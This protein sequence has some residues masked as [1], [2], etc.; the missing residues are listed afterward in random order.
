MGRAWIIGM[1]IGVLA[2]WA[3][4]DDAIAL[5]GGGIELRV[6]ADGKIV[7]VRGADEGH[8]LLSDKLPPFFFQLTLNGKAR[9]PTAVRLDED[10]KQLEFAYSDT[11]ITAQVA[12]HSC[13]THLRL[14][15]R[16]VHGA[17]AERVQLLRLPLAIQGRVGRVV[18]V[19]RDGE[20][21][22]GVQGLNTHTRAGASKTGW[23]GYLYSC[24]EANRGGVIGA[25]MALF[26]CPAAEALKRIG[27]IE[28]A[29]GLPHPMLDGEWNKISRTA[30]RPY[31]IIR[32]SVQNMADVLSLAERGGFRY[33]YHSNPFDTW[34]H[35]VL[36]K[37]LFPEGDQ[38]LRQCADMAAGKGIRLGF[39]TLSGFI[40]TNDAYVT[41]VPD[42]RLGRLGS[43]TLAAD[44]DA[45]VTEI[46]VADA[47]PFKQRQ[48]LGAVLMGT[49]IATY[50]RLAEG[51]APKL[52]GVT[53]GAFGTTASAHRKGDD[54]GKL[55]D[56]NYRTLFPGI[57]NGMMDEMT[58]R[59][60][61]LVN[62]TG[63]GMMSFDGLEC[64]ASYEAGGDYPRNRF[65]DRCHRRWRYDVISGASNLLHYNWHWHTR[66]NW[67]ELTQS[68]KMDIDFYRAKNCEFYRDNL[69]PAGMGWWRISPMRADCEATRLEDVEYLLSKAAGNNATHA[70]STDPGILN[71]HGL[72]G[73]M[74]E[75]V[76]LWDD[77]R[78]GGAL[79]EAQR[80][81]LREKGKDFR[82]RAV[83][84][85]GCELVPVAYGPFYWYCSGAGRK[86]DSGTLTFASTGTPRPQPPFPIS[87][88]YAVQPI[89]FGVR[90]LPAYDYGNS[91]NIDLTPDPETLVREAGLHKEAPTIEVKRDGAVGGEAAL[92]LTASYGAAKKPSY[93]T[94]LCSTLPKA[95]NLSSH[96]GLGVWVEGDGKGE[97]LFIEIQDGKMVRP[98]YVPID[99]TGERYIELPL[100]EV[101]LKRF[102]DY[103][104]NNWSGFSSW[105]VT[106]K[107]FRYQRVAMVTMGYNAIP[108][109]TTVSCRVAGIKALRELPAKVSVLRVRCGEQE[110]T[111][112]PDLEPFQYLIYEGEGAA[113]VYDP[114]FREL[115]TVQPVGQ[116]TL[117]PGENRVG[118]GIECPG[119]A[120]WIRLQSRAVGAPERLAPTQGG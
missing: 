19:I 79:T 112:R 51:D 97:T 55:A 11:G 61:E 69:L 9:N 104:W 75:L 113:R 6:A 85:G 66:M 115:R 43:S 25:S 53:R 91:G 10:A 30:Q 88:P 14:T 48:A 35:F 67:G 57:A 111:F 119:P 98:Y 95:L 103:E 73:R 109:S 78:F 77:A 62:A 100:G 74:I 81:R 15:L 13:E 45:A 106:L 72:A 82:L 22:V 41:P 64:L 42:P 1:G 32:Y 40:T 86:S 94:R 83:P 107:G 80:E 108:P 58:D 101:S 120:P 46:P 44:I 37:K 8:E 71:R 7:G 60:V 92:R 16:A 5:R 117:Q 26:A 29:E 84:A 39:H 36:H 90:C 96:R 118:L 99:F 87:N 93:V 17:E 31:L 28:Q 4:A 54:I 2:G 24:A 33:V 47:A 23:G 27:E 102:Y 89:R 38:S 76:K 110:I 105:W 70:L 49:E 56:Y 116:V 52:V 34:G 20:T 18:G 50:D 65:V 3:T 68:A 63:V 59:L 114:D 12:V 21:A